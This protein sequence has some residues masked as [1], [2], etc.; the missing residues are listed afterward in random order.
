MQISPYCCRAF[1]YFCSLVGTGKNGNQIHSMTDANGNRRTPLTIVGPSDF[2]NNVCPFNGKNSAACCLIVFSVLTEY[3]DGSV[4]FLFYY[5]TVVGSVHTVFRS[6]VPGIHLEDSPDIY[7]QQ[8]T[9]VFHCISKQS[10]GMQMLTTLTEAERTLIW[11]SSGEWSSMDK[12]NVY[13]HRASEAVKMWGKLP[14]WVMI[15]PVFQRS[16]L[17]LEKKMFAHS[18]PFQSAALLSMGYS[19]YHRSAPFTWM[20]LSCNT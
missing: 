17:Q 11:P 9:F 3:S 2:R 16:C 6:S 20:G 10:A 5:Q 8:K 12:F 13:A 18:L 4:D 15:L 7:L 19:R 14:L 1:S